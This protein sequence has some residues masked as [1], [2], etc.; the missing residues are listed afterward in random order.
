M[1]RHTCASWLLQRGTRSWDAANFLGVSDKIL[2]EVYGHH[3]PDFQSGVAGGK[4]GRPGRARAPRR[5]QRP[6]QPRA[7]PAD[8]PQEP[9]RQA[10]GPGRSAGRVNESGPARPQGP[11]RENSGG[12]GG[13]SRVVLSSCSFDK[14]TCLPRAH[15]GLVAGSS[16]AG[17]SPSPHL[18]STRAGLPSA[19]HPSGRSAASE[20]MRD[21]S[22]K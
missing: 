9:V 2:L 20:R 22:L 12:N 16:P 19:K 7:G 14:K 15:S 17:P 8:R 13:V 10:E 18:Q 6:L 3:A 11:H 4:R 21:V 5:V 1:L